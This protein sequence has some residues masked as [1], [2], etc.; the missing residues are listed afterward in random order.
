MA[1]IDDPTIAG[2]PE[3]RR[4]G[5]R[6]LAERG[7]KGLDFV[8]NCIAL[9]LENG[10]PF[11]TDDPN[12]AALAKLYGVMAGS[13]EVADRAL[14]DTENLAKRDVWKDDGGPDWLG[15]D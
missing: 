11:L 4:L 7:E 2:S 5:A 1:R 13:S 15:G 6:I 8:L 3:A 12:A 10:G 14:R 9:C